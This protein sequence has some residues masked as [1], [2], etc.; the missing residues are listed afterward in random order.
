MDKFLLNR[1]LIPLII[2]TFFFYFQVYSKHL[3]SFLKRKVENKRKLETFLFLL[4]SLKVKKARL[5][6]IVLIPAASA[7]LLEVF[8]SFV[9]RMP[10]HSYFEPLWFAGLTSGFLA[11]VAEEFL[12][13]A[14]FLGSACTLL[15]SLKVGK[16]FRIFYYSLWLLLSSFVFLAGHENFTFFQVAVRFSSSILYGVLYLANERNVLPSIVAH[17]SAN[18]FIILKDLIF[19]F[20]SAI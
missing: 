15:F 18:W 17:A 9:F 4:D 13:R 12:T 3:E 11:P 10:L 14:I 1:F 8:L 5:E 6:R 16:K 7:I 20:E 19:G 2:T